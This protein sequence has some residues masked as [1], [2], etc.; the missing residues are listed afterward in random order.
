MINSLPPFFIKGD[1]MGKKMF[2]F[3][4]DT[5]TYSFLVLFKGEDDTVIEKI[6]RGDCV[7]DALEKCHIQDDAI[8]EVY[9]LSP[10]IDRK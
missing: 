9:G 10:L 8:I 5:E 1:Q 4:K 2:Y 6:I 7:H 3:D